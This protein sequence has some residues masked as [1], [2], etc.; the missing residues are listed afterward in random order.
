MIYYFSKHGLC[1][2]V[3]HNNLEFLTTSHACPIVALVWLHR[4]QVVHHVRHW[5]G[6]YPQLIEVLAS[7]YV[8]NK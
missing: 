5:T 1:L 4:A 2:P 3:P 8:F 6:A 7:E